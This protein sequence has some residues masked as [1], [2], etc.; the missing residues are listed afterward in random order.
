MFDRIDRLE[1]IDSTGRILVKH[2]IKI[3]TYIQDNGKTLKLVLY[4]R[5]KVS[6]KSPMDKCLECKHRIIEHQYEPNT[7]NK[8]GIDIT[9]RALEYVNTKKCFEKR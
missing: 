7:C 6:T 3:E 8:L 9:E 4:D 5:K 2:P 1:I